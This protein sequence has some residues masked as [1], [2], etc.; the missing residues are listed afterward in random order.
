MITSLNDVLRKLSEILEQSITYNKS[1]GI[2]TYIY[3]RTTIEIKK[4]IDNQQFDD[5]QRMEN[6]DI[7]FANL[8]LTSYKNYNNNREVFNSWKIAFESKSNTTVIQNLLL[9][10]NAHINLDLAIAA[11]QIMS[12]QYIHDLKNDF[13]KVNDILESLINELEEKISNTS[14]MFFLIDWLGGSSDEAIIDFSMRKARDFAWTSAVA[15]SILNEAD[16]RIKIENMD[17]M[18]SKIGEKISNPPGRLLK[19]ALRTIRF[20]EPNTVSKIIEKLKG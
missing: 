7:V 3:H 11:D 12:G 20:F 4:S 5:N 19:L 2:F 8:F 18:I 13:T 15:L 1:I 16:K 10:M 17:Y 9:G 6:F 14:T